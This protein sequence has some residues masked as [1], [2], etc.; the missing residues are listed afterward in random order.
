MNDLLRWPRR[1]YLWIRPHHNYPGHRRSNS[2]KDNWNWSCWI[3]KAR[4]HADGP[5]HRPLTMSLKIEDSVPPPHLF[6][7]RSATW[8]SSYSTQACSLS[9][10]SAIK[11]PQPT[12]PYNRMHESHMSSHNINN[13]PT[14]GWY[15]NSLIT[16]DYQVCLVLKSAMDIWL[17]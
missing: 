2:I 4:H 11:S 6:S 5:H 3:P 15:D 8:P 1:L 12:Q 10:S 17:T 16:P 9:S 13:L 14:T 7:G